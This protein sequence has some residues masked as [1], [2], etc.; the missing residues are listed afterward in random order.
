[1]QLF[2]VQ[3][4]KVIVDSLQTENLIQNKSIIAKSEK[5]KTFAEKVKTF[6]GLFN[7]INKANEGALL[8]EG[9]MR[10]F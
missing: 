7:A 5:Q 6:T 4:D 10:T 2:S 9:Q 8:N 3:N 1:M